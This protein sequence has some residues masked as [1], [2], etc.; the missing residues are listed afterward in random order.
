MAKKT[1]GRRPNGDGWVYQDGSQWRYKIA[2]GVDPASGRERYRGGR[3]NSH[4]EAT[5]KLRNLQVELRAGRLVPTSKGSLG[6][7]L[8]EWVENAIKPN[9]AD[10]TYRQYRW[11]VDAHIVPHLGKK[12]IDAVRRQDVQR[13]VAIKATQT[14][15]A[16]SAERP[17]STGKTL[18]RSTLRLIRAVLHAAFNDAI[19]DGVVALNPA[20]HVD[21]PKEVREPP[22]SLKAEQAGALLRAA[23]KSD[24]PEFW[25]FLFLT[26]TRLAEACGLRW[27]DV[28]LDEG[29]ARISGQLLRQG[30][31]LRHVPGTKTNRS[32]SVQMPGSLIELLRGLAARRLIEGGED[33]D[34]LVFLNPY[35]RRLDPKFVRDRL[36]ELCLEAGVPV[37]S[38]HK[39]RHTAA[40]LALGATGDLHAVQKMLGHAQISLTANLYGHGTAEAQRRVANALSDLISPRQSGPEQGSS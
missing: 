23:L 14:V 10:A 8:D 2:V 30:G 19:R 35:G 11:I 18:S 36:R 7:F 12:Q 39:A 40:T 29:E 24:M 15:Q 6:K 16:R 26:G 5:E 22:T 1:Q 21:L 3:A 28:D 37:V 31:E 17:Q 4:A 32:R 38:P 34:R 20:S 9:R 27:H 13:L 33:P 25:H